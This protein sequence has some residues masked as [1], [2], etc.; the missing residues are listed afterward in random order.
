MWAYNKFI[1]VPRENKRQEEADRRAR[2]RD[3]HLTTVLKPIMD[4]VDRIEQDLQKSKSDRE[5]L[6]KIADVN[7]NRIGELDHR[8]DDHEIRIV[9]VEARLDGSGRYLYDYKEE[10][11][12]GNL[13]ND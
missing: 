8:M 3:E 12:G 11:E 2:E 5:S 7:T 10:Y 9:R 6:N 4:I 1:G 13:E